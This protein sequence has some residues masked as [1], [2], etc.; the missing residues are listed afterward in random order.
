MSDESL[1]CQTLQTQKHIL[2]RYTH[3]TDKHRGET[4]EHIEVYFAENLHIF[5]ISPNPQDIL[6][7]LLRQILLT[8]N[9]F[10]SLN[11]EIIR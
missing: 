6:K 3:C 11:N 9:M 5:G 7:H 8:E 4:C 1:N 2:S 10:P